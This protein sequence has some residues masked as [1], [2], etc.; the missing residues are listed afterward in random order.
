MKWKGRVAVAV[1]V[2]VVLGEEVE[3]GGWEV[4]SL[5]M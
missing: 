2:V 5:G 4:G 1:A 3:G